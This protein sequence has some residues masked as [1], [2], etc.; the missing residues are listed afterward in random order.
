MWTTGEGSR[1]SLRRPVG[2]YSSRA[3]RVADLAGVSRAISR[4]LLATSYLRIQD[5]MKGVIAA[6]LF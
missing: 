5:C 3:E 1:T 6:V 4:K 2:K